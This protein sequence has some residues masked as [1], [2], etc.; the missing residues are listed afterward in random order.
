LGG[1]FV[2]M[3]N[4]DYIKCIHCGVTLNNSEE[5]PCHNCGKTG[6]KI[7]VNLHDSIKMSD[8]L[9]IGATS[10]RTNRSTIHSDSFNPTDTVK[11]Q[12][13]I[14]DFVEKGLDGLSP[15]IDSLVQNFD[16][17]LQG[18][19][20]TFYRGVDISVEKH[21]SS[22]KIGPSPNSNDG[23]YNVKG[24]KCIYLIDDI[25]FL[26][27]EIESSNAL[28]QRYDIPVYKFKIADLSS[29]NKDI[30]NSLALA[31]DMTENGRTSSGYNFEEA[32]ENCGK[33][34]YLVSQL[35][36]NIFKKYGWDGLYIPGVHGSNGQYYH[37]CTIFSTIANQWENWAIGSYFFKKFN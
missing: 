16:T 4:S 31:F 32:L 10:G 8:G 21:L 6:R 36:S 18:K 23:R 33:S 19:N 1:D 24:D 15:F 28:I 5:Q 34:K 3:N 35:L 17:T 27:S 29:N 9:V 25:D 11:I 13:L 7:H 2:G 26:F 14:I 37:N 22:K 20:I 12:K 30:H